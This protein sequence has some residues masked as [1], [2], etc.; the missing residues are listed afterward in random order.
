MN[1]TGFIFSKSPRSLAQATI[2]EAIIQFGAT[3]L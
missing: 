1:A 3:I 2:H